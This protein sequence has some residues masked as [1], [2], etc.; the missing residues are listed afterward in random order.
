MKRAEKR[1]E[2]AD[3]QSLKTELQLNPN[4]LGYNLNYIHYNFAH[5]YGWLKTHC[6]V[7]ISVQR[8]RYE[9]I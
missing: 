5:V 1:P 3:G 8:E 9:I 4:K 6:R 2:S 7:G